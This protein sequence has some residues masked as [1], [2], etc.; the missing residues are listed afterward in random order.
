MVEKLVVKKLTASETY[1]GRIHFVSSVLYPADRK[2]ESP[3]HTLNVI[4]LSLMSAYIHVAHNQA[5]PPTHTFQAMST[6]PQKEYCLY[7]INQLANSCFKH[8]THT[9]ELKN[10]K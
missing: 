10:H 2:I 7:A 3:I 6:T 8:H 5:P 4:Y 9:Q 1:V